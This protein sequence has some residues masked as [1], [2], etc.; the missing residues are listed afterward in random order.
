MLPP[1]FRLSESCC[2]FLCAPPF[3]LWVGFLG[4]GWWGCAG[5]GVCVGCAPCAALLVVLSVRNLGLASNSF[6]DSFLL[7][8]P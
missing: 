1:R 3:V 2:L 4:C 7:D 5:V 6:I 8:S